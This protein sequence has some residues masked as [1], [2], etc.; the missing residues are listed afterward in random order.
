MLAHYFLLLHALVLTLRPW[1]SDNINTAFMY[2]LAYL[3][4]ELPHVN[5]K[6][7]V[8]NMPITNFYS[9]VWFPQH[10][11]HNSLM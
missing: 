4:G 3:I 9:V 2:S 10:F 5:S 6:Q 1:Y 7:H 8:Y 11:G